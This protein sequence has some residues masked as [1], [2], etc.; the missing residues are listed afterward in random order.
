ME[1]CHRSSYCT[2]VNSVAYPPQT[3]RKIAGKQVNVTSRRTKT[4]KDFLLICDSKWF[5]VEGLWRQS[6]AKG[7][8]GAH[9]TR[10]RR[11]RSTSQQGDD[12]DGPGR[13]FAPLGW[14][15]SLWERFRL[16]S[17]VH[18]S[19]DGRDSLTTYLRAAMCFGLLFFLF[20]SQCGFNQKK[21]TSVFWDPAKQMTDSGT[22]E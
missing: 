21:D 19:M 10:G 13:A 6:S 3:G 11:C 8:A 22:E 2:T 17:N 14:P 12:A 7:S 9:S 16:H 1:E 15:W 18:N 5:I 20:C 4:Q